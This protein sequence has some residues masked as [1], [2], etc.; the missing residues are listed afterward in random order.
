MFS[1]T[2]QNYCYEISDEWYVTMVE[3]DEHTPFRER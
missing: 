3:I 2:Y 1:V